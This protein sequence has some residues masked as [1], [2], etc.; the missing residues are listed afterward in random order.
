MYFKEEIFGVSFIL[1]VGLL[2]EE[3]DVS[4]YVWRLPL[5]SILMDF[6]TPSAS[7]PPPLN[8]LV[9]C[10]S[11]LFVIFSLLGSPFCFSSPRESCC[12]SDTRTELPISIGSALLRYLSAE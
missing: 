5:S 7:T 4:S 10:D 12:A 11:D 3:S 8:P 1:S 2:C 6:F 9:E